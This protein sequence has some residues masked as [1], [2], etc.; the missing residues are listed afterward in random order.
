[1]GGN[2]PE[3]ADERLLTADFGAHILTEYGR[4]EIRGDPPFG[5]LQ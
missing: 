3:D 2:H 4:L 5:H 1:M